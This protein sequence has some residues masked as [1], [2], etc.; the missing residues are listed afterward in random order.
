MSP[1]FPI[2]PFCNYYAYT[3]QL[4]C[5]SSRPLASRPPF[6]TSY[7]LCFVDFTPAFWVP[8]SASIRFLIVVMH[9]F[10]LPSICL[11]MAKN[12]VPCLPIQ[13]HARMPLCLCL[14]L[15]SVP[16]ILL[17]VKL[18][19]LCMA[20]PACTSFFAPIDCWRFVFHHVFFAT[21]Y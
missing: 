15:A 14:L 12:L 11:M 3:I 4:F 2:L 1:A 7:C 9:D 13:P 5:S 21:S 19:V 17:P 18:P 16:P 20:R 10:F 8:K 6:Y